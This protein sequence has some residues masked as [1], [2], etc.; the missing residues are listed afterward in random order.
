M[1]PELLSWLAS[2]NKDPVAFVLG[3]FPWAEEE[4]SLA[5]FSGPDP[6]QLE[7]LCL[8]R[9]GLLTLEEAI[10]L[11]IASGHGIGKSALVAWIILWGF[12]HRP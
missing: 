9:D 7:I 12:H 1:N 4:S 3:A 6:W 2:C 10:L 11:A 8:I 5:S